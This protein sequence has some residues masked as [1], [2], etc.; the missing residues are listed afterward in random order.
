LNFAYSIINGFSMWSLKEGVAKM[1]QL[2]TYVIYLSGISG[3]VEADMSSG[4][5]KSVYDVLLQEY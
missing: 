3:I 1:V 4:I 2:F 5:T